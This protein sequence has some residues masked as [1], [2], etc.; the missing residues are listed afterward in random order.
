MTGPRTPIREEP[1]REWE[2]YNLWVNVKEALYNLPYQF[3]TDTY[4]EGVSLTDLPTLSP[5][6]GTTIEQ[7][8]VDNLNQIRSV[9]DPEGRYSEYAFI[10][11]AQTFP[12]VL[13]TKS[14]GGD[15]TPILGIELKTWYLLAKEKEP[16]FRFCATKEACAPADLVVIVP[17]LLSQVISGRPKLLKPFVENA[18]YVAA[19]RNYYWE[20]TRQTEDD[21]GI[22]VPEDVRP[23]PRKSD[24]INDRPVSDRGKNFGRIARTGIMEEY[25]EEIYN[26]RIAGIEIRHWLRFVKIFSEGRTREE[27]E[28]EFERFEREIEQGR[29]GKNEGKIESVWMILTGLRRL[30]WEESGT[31]S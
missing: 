9:W 24:A 23:Y 21:R 17:W 12:D 1:S 13:L 30:I 4:I 7:Q 18:R 22:I 15:I 31:D 26:E 3:H 11:Q 6:V 27:I 14:G 28:Q 5:A 16:N 2:H 10:R 19:W 25:I 29:Y 20:H 8:L